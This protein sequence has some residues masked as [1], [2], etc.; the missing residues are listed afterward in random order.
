MA[1]LNEDDFKVSVK[2]YSTKRIAVKTNHSIDRTG[3]GYVKGQKGYNSSIK[4]RD[5]AYN[6]LKNIS[7]DNIED[8]IYSLSNLDLPKYSKNPEYRPL[9]TKD[10]IN[11]DNEEKE[12]YNISE[13][14]TTDIFGFSP[15]KRTMY[16]LP[17]HSKFENLNTYFKK[18][19]KTHIIILNNNIFTEA[20]KS[21]TFKKFI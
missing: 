19:T 7:D 8:I 4:R 11:L 10:K 2:D 3:M 16:I 6:F 1:N 13:Y 21:A 15:E 18:E 14:Y 9:R 20:F 17:I 12:K 5:I